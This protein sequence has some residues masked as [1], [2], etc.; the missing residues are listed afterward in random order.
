VEAGQGNQDDGGAGEAQAWIGE[1][2]DEL[3]ALLVGEERSD[4]SVFQDWLERHPAFVPGARGPGG[5]TGHDPWPGALISQ[6]R[7]TGINAKQPDFCWLAA[8]SAELT[9]VMIEI[10]TPAKRWQRAG[11]AVQSAE[12]TQAFEQIN[13]WRVWF[14]APHNQSGFLEEY[15]V[16]DELRR[17]RFAQYYILVHGSRSEY[18]GDPER[19]RQRAA[20]LRTADFQG[21]SFDR[22][23]EL[24]DTWSTRL[25]CVRR[26]GPG[27]EAVAVPATWDPDYLVDRY[28][29]AA[30]GYEEAVAASPMSEERRAHALEVLE[31][32][33]EEAPRPVRFHP[34]P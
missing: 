13:A 15:L 22:L 2:R 20:M 8:D 10:E 33:A 11:E 24:P 25:G 31:R 30:A 21:M 1:S 17:L 5:N 12:L 27:F 23:L 34:E 7:L 26:R 4:E 29:T 3:A 6:P 14:N 19:V 9:A 32:L 28:V 16:P 18:E